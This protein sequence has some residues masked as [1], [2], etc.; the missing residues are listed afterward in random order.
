[1]EME[2]DKIIDRVYQKHRIKIDPGDPVFQ[3]LYLLVEQN[4]QIEK[5]KQTAI[6]QQIDGVVAAA[7]AKL[8]NHIEAAKIANREIIEELLTNFDNLVEMRLGQRKG[9][10]SPLNLQ[11]WIKSRVTPTL[12]IIL[13]VI[14]VSN[15]STVAFVVNYLAGQ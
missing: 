14:V 7:A 13:A 4:L 15:L 5:D 2:I 10:T 9:N 8:D 11:E 3:V 12:L 1:M 6:N